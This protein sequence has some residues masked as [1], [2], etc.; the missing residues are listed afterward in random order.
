MQVFHAVLMCA[1]AST[2]QAAGTQVSG[3]IPEH[4]HSERKLERQRGHTGA[5]GRGGHRGDPAARAVP[6]R[7][8]ARAAA[9]ADAGARARTRA[10]L[11]AAEDLHLGPARRLQRVPHRAARLPRRARYASPLLLC[12]CSVALRFFLLQSLTRIVSFFSP[13][14]L[15]Y[16]ECYKKI[17]LLSLTTLAAENREIPYDLIAKMLQIKPE[18]VESW[19]VSA[20]AAELI[21]ARM[22]QLRRIVVI[23]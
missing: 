19:V 6:N 10:H 5:G 14:G 17:R 18:E 7:P 2:A 16:E 21:D 4:V 20:I 1:A 13:S 15:S 12:C 23:R 11:P 3:A 9:G 22:D 8:R